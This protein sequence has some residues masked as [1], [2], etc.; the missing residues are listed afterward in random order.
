[1]ADMRCLFST[2]SMMV[3]LEDFRRAT[4]TEHEFSTTVGVAETFLTKLVGL[5]VGV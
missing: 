1:M 2:R 3:S 5:D 4:D